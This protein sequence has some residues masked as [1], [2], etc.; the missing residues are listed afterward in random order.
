MVM[1]FEEAAQRVHNA[2]LRMTHPREVLLRLAL[3]SA[4]P[5]S[6][7][8]LRDRAA[9]M[10]LE[11]SLSTVYRN[12]AAFVQAHL[13]DELPGEDNRLYAWHEDQDTNAH[14]FCLDCRRMTALEGIAPGDSQSDDALSKA[15]NQRGF[16]ASTVR[17]MLAVHCKTQTCDQQDAV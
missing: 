3:E 5:F 1:T 10:G 11:C 2:G 4:R 8:T 17:M 15:L 16:D 13:V 12:L 7:E 14:V 9:Q 6:V